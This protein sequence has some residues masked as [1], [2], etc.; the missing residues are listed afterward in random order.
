MSQFTPCKG[1]S[2]CRDEGE[3]CLTCGRTFAEITALREAID[4]LATLAI[5]YDYRNASDYSDYI[6]RKLVK[7]IAHRRGEGK[8]D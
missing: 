3:R 1:K 7:V 4:Q 8:G 6:A 5:N 2:L